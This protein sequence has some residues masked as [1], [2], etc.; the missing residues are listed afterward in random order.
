M[1]AQ[2]GLRTIMQALLIGTIIL[3][4]NKPIARELARI[5]SAPLRWIFGEKLWVTKTQEYFVIWMRITL[6]AGSLISFVAVISEFA[7]I[8][9]LF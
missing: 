5:F 3:V 6:Y 7:N 8:Y 2:E 9:Q 4:Y 1:Y